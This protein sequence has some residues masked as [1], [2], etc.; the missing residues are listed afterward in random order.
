MAVVLEPASSWLLLP[1]NQSYQTAS[2]ALRRGRV[3]IRYH[4]TNKSQVQL[5]S[6]LPAWLRWAF[7]PRSVNNMRC[8]CMPRDLK[9]KIK[10]NIGKLPGVLVLH[11]S[12][13]GIHDDSPPPSNYCRCGFRGRCEIES[14][15]RLLNP[16]ENGQKYMLLTNSYD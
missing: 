3:K 6:P 7:L 16:E 9:V 1:E 4:A 5:L 10:L 13:F 11:H 2:G 14:L 15:N 12:E 8:T